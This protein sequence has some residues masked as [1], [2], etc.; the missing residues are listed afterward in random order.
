MNDYGLTN[1]DG[2]VMTCLG[3]DMGI[4]NAQGISM[5]IMCI[6]SLDG[7]VYFKEYR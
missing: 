4:G 1:N 5:R 6:V 2:Y 3:W 7:L